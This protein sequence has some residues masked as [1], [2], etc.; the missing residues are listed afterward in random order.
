LKWL[1]RS[2]NQEKS[3]TIGFHYILI[4]PY[5]RGIYIM[6]TEST[7]GLPK[8][9]EEVAVKLINYGFRINNEGFLWRITFPKGEKLGPQDAACYG[10]EWG[11]IPGMSI[12]NDAN[13]I[14]IA[15]TDLSDGLLKLLRYYEE[16]KRVLHRYEQFDRA[17]KNV[18]YG[19]RP[20]DT[21]IG[22]AGCGP[23]SLAIV[24]QYLMNNG[25]RPRNACHVVSP[26]ETAKYAATHGRVSG[27][28]TAGDPMINGIK[29]RWP[30]FDGVRVDLSQ[31]TE[32]IEEGKLILFLCKGCKGKNYRGK[33]IG[34]GGHYM[35]LAGVGSGLGPKRTFYVVDPGR[36]ERHAMRSITYSELQ[37]HVTGFWWVY[38]AEEL[39]G[40]SR[41]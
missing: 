35:V 18:V 39:E 12:A 15:K 2:A 16:R 1:C 5:S 19:N 21:T 27:H 7:H 8:Q 38:S 20:G 13:S 26:L 37:R 3:G 6:F 28:G 22:Q 32:L 33:P 31:A 24:L 25:L 10:L 17:W 14:G 11:G 29:K 36:N 4:I 23:T 34:Y 9:L 30:G 41:E 40:V